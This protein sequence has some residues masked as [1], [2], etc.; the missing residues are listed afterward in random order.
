VGGRGGRLSLFEFPVTRG[1]GEGRHYTGHAEPSLACF[2]CGD[3]RLVTAGESDRIVMQWVVE[4]AADGEDA[5]AEET[6]EAESTGHVRIGKLALLLKG[7]IYDEWIAVAENESNVLKTVCSLAR[8]PPRRIHIVSVIPAND[9]LVK[10]RYQAPSLERV[11]T[12]L[13]TDFGDAHGALRAIKVSK[14][15]FGEE[16]YAVLNKSSIFA[17]PH[18]HGDDGDGEF[19]GDRP[20]RQYLDAVVEPA[21][22]EARGRGGAA[23]APREE[24]EMEHVHG[25]RGRGCVGILFALESGDAMYL[26]GK[27][28]VVLDVARN[29]QFFFAKHENDIGCVDLHPNGTLVATGD[30]GPGPC[31]CVWS[32]ATMEVLSSWAPQ[33]SPPTFQ[34]T[35]PSAH[36]PFS[37][38]TLQH[39]YPSAQ[40]P[41]A[42]NRDILG[43][44]ACSP[45]GCRRQACPKYRGFVELRL[46][47]E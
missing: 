16:A 17:R 36:R 12:D 7:E 30:V 33:A 14:L 8:I 9:I 45:R 42:P 43:E 18:V 31:I 32:S 21:G 20:G 4:K 35:D 27:L 37:T 47:F 5:Q 44:C 41:S 29:R 39:T 28:A 46:K 34:H 24:L 6:G 22:A 19:R 10:L 3:G 2:A 40:L 25:F 11:Q 15:L 38:L 1:G 13:A 23:L 26:A